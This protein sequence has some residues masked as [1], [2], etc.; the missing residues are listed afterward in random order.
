VSAETEVTA[1]AVYPGELTADRMA[2]ALDGAPVDVDSLRKEGSDRWVASAELE[3]GGGGHEVEFRAGAFSSKRE[4]RVENRLR[5]LDPLCHP[6]PVRDDAGFFYQLT[7]AADEVTVE[8]YTVTGRKIRVLRNLSARAGHNGNPG[9]WDGRDQDGDRLARG[10]YPF[11]VIASRGGE[12]AEALGRLVV[13][14]GE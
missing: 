7:L 8:I 6:N 12:R 11:R 2:F 9:V 5:L 4:I 10:V 3:L 1:T 13:M 14:W